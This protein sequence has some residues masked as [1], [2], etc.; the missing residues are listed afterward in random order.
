MIRATIYKSLAEAQLGPW[1][2]QMKDWEANVGKKIYEVIIIEGI[3]RNENPHI[4][5]CVSTKRPSKTYAAMLAAE[6]IMAMT[7]QYPK[8]IVA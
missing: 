3:Y 7:K 5:S 2:K 6:M 1:G 4:I 8:S